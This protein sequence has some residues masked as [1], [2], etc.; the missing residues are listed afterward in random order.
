MRAHGVA[1]PAPNASGK[2]PVFNTTR[3]D[4]STT[5]YKSANTLCV[6]TLLQD[7]IH[8]GHLHGPGAGKQIKP[9]INLE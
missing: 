8:P 7:T 1:L 3:I 2:G 5:A 4:T 9:P 6:H